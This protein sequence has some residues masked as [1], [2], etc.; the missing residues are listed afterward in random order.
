MRCGI[1]AEERGADAAP[2]AEAVDLAAGEAEA[3]PVVQGLE[4]VAPAVLPALAAE[5]DLAGQAAA[6]EVEVVAEVALAGE[7][8]R[9]GAIE[10]Y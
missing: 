2:G 8:P 9:Q 1:Y 7:W 10:L 6:A 5:E 3:G 4:P